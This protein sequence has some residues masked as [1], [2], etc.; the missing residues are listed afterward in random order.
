VAAGLGIYLALIN[1]ITFLAFA[2]DKAS[3]KARRSRIPERILL[4]L[5]GIGG[6]LGAVAGQVLLRHKTRKEPFAAWLRLILFVQ[7]VI[8]TA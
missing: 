8:V 6:G 5:A 2:S 7:A 4:Q 3:A 1:L